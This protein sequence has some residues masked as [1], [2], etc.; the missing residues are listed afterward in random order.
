M[1]RE[2]GWKM[3]YQRMLLNE[4]RLQSPGTEWEPI[5]PQ[6]SRAVILPSYPLG[7]R[8]TAQC[9]VAPGALVSSFIFTPL[10]QMRVV[11]AL[12]L[13][14][15]IILLFFLRKRPVLKISRSC[16]S[17]FLFSLYSEYGGTP[18]S[19]RLPIPEQGRPWLEFS[20]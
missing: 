14:I 11:F 2:C 1:S 18:W 13:Q 16:C 5:K 7:T 6:R 9:I 15:S 17:L 20:M 10:L 19:S 12:V 3:Q 4:M 8:L